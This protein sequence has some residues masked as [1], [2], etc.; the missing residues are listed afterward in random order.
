MKLMLASK[1]QNARPNFFPRIDIQEWSHNAR[2]NDLTQLLIDLL[3]LPNFARMLADYVS[4][5][6]FFFHIFLY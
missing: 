6:N 3:G 2:P 5:H 4:Q 1:S